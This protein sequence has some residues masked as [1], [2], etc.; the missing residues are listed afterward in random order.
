MR[1]GQSDGKD[2]ASAVPCGQAW[3]VHLL[4]FALRRHGKS[5]LPSF[6]ISGGGRAHRRLIRSQIPH[7]HRLIIGTRQECVVL[8]MHADRS[9]SATKTLS[10]AKK[11]SRKS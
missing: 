6:D 11:F 5:E 4:Q 7:Q 9:D 1:L 3:A 10:S 2:F 8:W